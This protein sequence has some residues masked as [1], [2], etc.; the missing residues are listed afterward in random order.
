MWSAHEISQDLGHATKVS[1]P[2]IQEMTLADMMHD[3]M[4]AVVVE[5]LLFSVKGERESLA[6][7][8][9]EAEEKSAE[10]QAHIDALEK[11]PLSNTV[12]GEIQLVRGALKEYG[13]LTVQITSLAKDAKDAEAMALFPTFMKSFRVLEEKMESMGELIAKETG[14]TQE[15]AAKVQMTNIIVSLF[16]ASLIALLCWMSARMLNAQLKFYVDQLMSRSQQMRA[17]DQ[18]LLEATNLLAENSSQNAASLE[19]SSATVTQLYAIGEENAKAAGQNAANSLKAQELANLGVEGL[20][21]LSD[22]VKTIQASS[23]QMKEITQVIDDIAFQTNLLALN[24]A[25]EA[26]RAGE[27]GRGFAV[28]ADAVRSL[29]QKSA[30]AAKQIQQLIS[31]SSDQVNTSSKLSEQAQSN[32]AQIQAQISSVYSLNQELAGRNSEQSLSIGQ[33]RAS[34][35][36]LQNS[37]QTTAETAENLRTNSQESSGVTSSVIDLSERLKLFAGIKDSSGDKHAA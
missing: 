31:T 35:E 24:A 9:T 15:S 10:F 20:K 14:A 19:E 3:G 17:I 12:K 29:A 16:F 4:R 5:S 23:V 22:A 26:A 11:L 2:A 13:D 7:L 32:F 33:M 34:L 18:V 25:V 27:H 21:K 6:S 36:A 8:A 1:F 37:A 28:V 30:Q